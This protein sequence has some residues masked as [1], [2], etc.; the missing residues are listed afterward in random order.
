MD[1]HA[2]NFISSRDA[3]RITTASVHLVEDVLHGQLHLRIC[4][5][6][7]RRGCTAKR[8]VVVKV[9]ARV[10]STDVKYKTLSIVPQT[11]SKEIVRMLL[12]KFRMKH[13]D[14]NL[15][16]LAM[17]V[18]IRKTGLPIRTVLMLD[19]EARPGELQACHPGGE[20]RFLSSNPPVCRFMLQMRRGGLVKVYDSCLMTGSLYK[21]LLVSDKTTTEELIQLLL[22]CY[23]SKER[24]TKFALFETSSIQKY[25]RKLH[26]QDYPLLIQQGWPS[27]EHFAF[28]LRRNIDCC[29]KQKLFKMRSDNV[30]GSKTF[31]VCLR[32]EISQSSYHSMTLLPSVSNYENYFYI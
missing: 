15:Y 11:T 2:I 12:N 26:P 31:G 32:D 30:S 20:F 17:E 22:H 27:Q 13:R 1:M 16:Y 29:Q 9:Y 23:N 25:E 28:L 6:H 10:L 4:I 3:V 18:W 5:E 24:P 8:L 14:P 19:D 21:S 7:F